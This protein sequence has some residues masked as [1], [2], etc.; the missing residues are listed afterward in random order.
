MKIARAVG[1]SA[2]GMALVF[3]LLFVWIGTV[4]VV[5]VYTTLALSPDA[6]LNAMLT[7]LLSLIGLPIVHHALYR[8][9]WSISRRLASG[10]LK[11][12]D[13]MPV[14]GVAPSL[15][16]PRV[17]KTG[18]QHVLYLAIYALAIAS[19]LAAY[20]PLG[21]QAMLNTFLAR[22]SVGRSSFSSLAT[23]IVV[24][25]PML[26]GFVLA[27]PLLQR[28]RKRLQSGTLDATEALRLTLRQDWLFS[29]ITAYVTVGFLAFVAGN[30]I[31]KYL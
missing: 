23:L 12:G 27:L 20:A 15:P 4:Y 9:F 16:V 7:G 11:I 30:M 1:I 3:V 19:L 6:I 5:N 17:R 28:D 22:F 31:L 24:Y 2:L 29:F 21:H 18:A 8:H 14:M 13:D 26:V 10:E 25:A